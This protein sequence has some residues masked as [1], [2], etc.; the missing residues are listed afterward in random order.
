MKRFFLFVLALIRLFIMGK[1]LYLLY[2]TY[3]DEVNY[4]LDKL[5]W[6][7]YYLIFDIWVIQ[8]F[9]VPEDLKED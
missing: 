9:N 5:T 6:W 8:T 1:I 4:P 3:V 7:I 2:K